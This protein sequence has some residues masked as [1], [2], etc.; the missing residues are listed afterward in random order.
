VIVKVEDDGPG[1]S[2]EA[3]DDLF[4]P[5]FTTKDHGTGLGLAVSRQI[6]AAH[7]GELSYRERLDGGACFILS[8]PLS[9]PP[10]AN[11]V[12]SSQA[13][14]SEEGSDGEAARAPVSKEEN[15]YPS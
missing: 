15:R 13:L 12:P 14:R 11:R 7:G 5:F 4:D 9:P 1:I 6:L 3:A 10:Q 8:L 2:P